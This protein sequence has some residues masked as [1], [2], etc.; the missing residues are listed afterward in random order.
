MQGEI[1]T[2]LGG[3]VM[4]IEINLYASF[5]AGRFI[6]EFRDFP[7]KYTVRQVMTD[8]GIPEKA[9]GMSLANGRHIT[10]DQE[11]NDGDM[12]DLFP[13]LAGG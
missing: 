7:E 2:G 13:L 5:R 10:M 6:K 9:I 12:L 1:S 11:L 3:L 8:I 4:K